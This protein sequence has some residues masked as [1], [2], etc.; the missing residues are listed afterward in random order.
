MFYDQNSTHISSFFCQPFAETA[1]AIFQ[2]P[3]TPCDSDRMDFD[4]NSLLE[5]LATRGVDIGLKILGAFALWIIGG[6][7]IGLAIKL[8]DRALNRQKF[9]QTLRLY[10]TSGLSV[11]LKVVL[12]VAIL[13]FFGIETTSFAALLAGAGL[14][15]GTAWSG[16]LGNF[17]S[18]IFMVVLR[19][20]STGDFVKAGGVVG[21]VEEI[22]LFVTTINTMD[23]V[24]TIIGNNKIFSDTI[25]NF[26]ANPHRRVEL[27]AQ[28][29]HTVDP[30]QAIEKLQA[31]VS[32]I[33]HVASSPA[34][35]INILEFNLAGPVLSVRPY[36]HNDHYW[37][38]FF[39]TNKAIRDTFGEAGYPVPQKHLHI[40]QAA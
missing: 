27:L 14:A 20:F 1:K 38:V 34:P 29:N 22:G 5:T 11:V 16:L 36:T 26:T 21:T 2:S 8:V 28:L 25:Q 39:A 30:Q 23:N 18:G 24:K 19:P 13:G 12:V 35:E 32:A 7:L 40:N 10:I 33:N 31:A 9:D 37:D 3:P 6:W 17:A 4:F 15:I